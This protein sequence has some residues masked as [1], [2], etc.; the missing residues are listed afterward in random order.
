[1]NMS[2]KSRKTKTSD[3]EQ[4]SFATS[5]EISQRV[6]KRDKGCGSCPPPKQRCPA[7]AKKVTSRMVIPDSEIASSIG[8]P[9]SIDQ[10][11]IGT[12]TIPSLELKDFKGDFTYA[13]CKA[14]GVELEITLSISTSFSGTIHTPWFMPDLHPKG[15]V[16]FA[17]FTDKYSLGNIDF[18]SGSFSMQSPEMTMGPF[19]MTA[20]PIQGTTVDEVTTQDVKM[21]CTSIPLE[22]PLCKGLGICLPL[23]NPM[24][25]NNVI[26]EETNIGRMESRKI[27]SSRVVMKDISALNINIPS[28]TTKGFKATSTT[29]MHITMSKKTYGAG[30]T[31]TGD[32][33]DADIDGTLTLNIE[34]VI[35]N[36]KDG[37]E[38]SNVK[39]KVTTASAISDKLDI[40]LILKGIKIKG[41]NLCGMEI[42]E[43]EVEF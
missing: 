8:G 34:K 36:V 6:E 12:M 23:L 3:I 40:N 10:I 38:F 17:S 37:L 11:E 39:G 15:T 13:S 21:K 42:P 30:V 35:M 19:S 24:C 22:T 31:R 2:N 4:I 20:E 1:M 14:K 16:K 32:A 25:P 33:K 43:M 5:K 29:P 28:V 7:Q 18:Q 27:S 41:L 9:V 26:T